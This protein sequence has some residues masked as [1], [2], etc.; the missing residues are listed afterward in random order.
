MNS[1][2]IKKA[3]LRSKIKDKLSFINNFEEKND[4]IFQKLIKDKN[5]IKA[6]K[7]LVFSNLLFEPDTNRLINYLLS[8]NK[9]LFF[10]KCSKVD[11]SMKF[12]KIES[13]DKLVLG[14]YNIYEPQGN[15]LEFD[16]SSSENALCIVPGL[17][18]TKDGA[19]L[20]RGKGYY[21][22]YLE[23]FNGFCVGLCFKEQILMELP[24][25]KNDFSV[26]YVICD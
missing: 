5:L 3:R 8:K 7:V 11:N 25:N 17:A 19:R 23:K 12:Y 14:A 20:G 13:L 2:D 21:D 18:F 1:I 9:S 15:T 24:T 16:L 6:S 10:P 4:I 22:R 26:H